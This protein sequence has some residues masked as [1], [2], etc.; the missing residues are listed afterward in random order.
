MRLNHR[1]MK[2][3]RQKINFINHM[4]S[5]GFKD[6]I[7]ASNFVASYVFISVTI[8]KKT[9]VRKKN[10]KTF[11]IF[12]YSK[13][14]K[15]PVNFCSIQLW[16]CDWCCDAFGL[17]DSADVL[18]FASNMSPAVARKLSLVFLKL[19][20]G[21]ETFSLNCISV[22]LSLVCFIKYKRGRLLPRNTIKFASCAWSLGY[23]QYVSGREIL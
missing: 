7:K 12:L 21:S 16:Q 10:V 6:S 3:P 13:L 2:P 23:F 9:F 4:F 11:L 22:D 17:S 5:Q 14:Y 8:G 20:T 18:W 19:K 1:G 15:T